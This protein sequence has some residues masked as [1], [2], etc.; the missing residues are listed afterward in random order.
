[1]MVMVLLLLSSERYSRRRQNCIKPNLIAMKSIV[2]P[3]KAGNYG[4][5]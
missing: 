3:L 1:M 5:L 4:P 2:I